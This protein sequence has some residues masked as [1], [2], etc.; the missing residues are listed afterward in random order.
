MSCDTSLELTQPEH[1]TSCC[2]VCK[3]AEYVMSYCGEEMWHNVNPG[4]KGIVSLP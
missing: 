1:G 2:V 4:D 3:T